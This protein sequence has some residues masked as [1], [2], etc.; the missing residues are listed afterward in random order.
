M[1]AHQ[2]GREAAVT[3]DARP[4]LPQ[5]WWDGATAAQRGMATRVGIAGDYGAKSLYSV[6]VLRVC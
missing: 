3:C 4:E 2:G 1:G 6:T 5:G